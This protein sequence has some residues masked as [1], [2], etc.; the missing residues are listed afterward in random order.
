MKTLIK[1]LAAS[2][3]LLTACTNN[4]HPLV[5]DTQ[6]LPSQSKEIGFSTYSDLATKANPSKTDLEYYHNNFVVY[7]T[8]LYADG[9]E[10]VFDQVE[11]TS[12]VG[13]N[14][15]T[16]T[17]S[18]IRYW[19]RQAENYKFVA[20]APS[21][22]KIKYAFAAD[23]SQVGDGGFVS[24]EVTTLVGQNV[25]Q[26]GSE[27]LD[28]G[29]DGGNGKDADVMI[30]EVL[31]EQTPATAGLVN[32]T[33]KHTLAKLMVTLKAASNEYDVVI[34]EVKVNDLLSQGEYGAN[35]WQ[36]GSYTGTVDYGYAGTSSVSLS[37]EAKKYFIESLV[38]PQ[39]IADQVVTIRYTL[40]SKNDANYSE[41][42]VYTKKLSAIFG[43]SFQAA[44]K[45][46]VNFTI[47]P[48][49]IRF[50]ANATAWQDGADQEVEVYTEAQDNSE[51]SNEDN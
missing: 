12:V 8:K 25:A 36:V 5:E 44:Y 31:T 15:N 19:D 2:A 22:A 4:I 9:V 26:A 49:L 13:E 10:R 42:Y 24:T 18:P 29:F 38:M 30:S 35:G 17:Y 7:G 3:L 27:E 23:D 6:V 37:H 46:Q 51:T 14:A 34:R 40:Q 43:E 32:L 39:T 33:F 50:E 48:D 1:T 45:Y 41:K 11:V 21:T 16:W 47:S 28:H 20:F